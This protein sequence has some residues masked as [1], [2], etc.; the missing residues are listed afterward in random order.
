[1][2]VMNLPTSE[3]A[4]SRGSH[5]E[6][7]E[8]AVRALFANTAHRAAELRVSAHAGNYPFRE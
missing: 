5:G 3:F 1:M 2:W 8:S 6:P 7:A 4:A